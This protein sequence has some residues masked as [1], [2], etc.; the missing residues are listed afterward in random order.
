MNNDGRIYS[1]GEQRFAKFDNSTYSGLPLS[2]VNRSV[3]CD[4]GL[5]DWVAPNMCF[6]EKPV[7]V[8]SSLKIGE[9]RYDRDVGIDLASNKVVIILDDSK[10]PKY[11]CKNLP[12]LLRILLYYRFLVDEAI[13]MVGRKAMLDNAVPDNVIDEFEKE[14]ESEDA[15]AVEIDSFW[16]D[17]IERLRSHVIDD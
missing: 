12:S 15:S 11:V 4:V 6:A 7:L 1:W 3:L 13:S 9:D 14:V 8:G 10:R 16:K 2:E 5:P 17:E